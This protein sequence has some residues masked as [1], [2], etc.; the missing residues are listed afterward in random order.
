MKHLRQIIRRLIT[1]SIQQKEIIDGYRN[2]LQST[3]Q[4]VDTGKGHLN[5]AWATMKFEEWAIEAGIDPKRIGAIYLIEP[6]RATI[7]RLKERGVLKP[8]YSN[9]GEAHIA[10]TL[11]D[12]ILDF[13][14][15][16][17]DSSGPH[18]KVTPITQWREVY[19][20]YGYG[21][22]NGVSQDPFY[23]GKDCYIGSISLIRSTASWMTP[24][25]YQPPLKEIM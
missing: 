18:C 25:D 8:Y 24:E 3:Y 23:G 17:F 22:G 19:G 9:E 16:Q 6:S 7:A 4:F 20:P 1:E 15:R 12:Q 2:F 5:C 14:W 11:D 21:K 10:P 13:T